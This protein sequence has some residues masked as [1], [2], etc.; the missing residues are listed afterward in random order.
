MPTHPALP[1]LPS[2]ASSPHSNSNP[3]QSHP[4]IVSDLISSLPDILVHLLPNFL[5]WLAESGIEYALF[6]CSAILVKFVL[7]GQPYHHCVEIESQGITDSRGD[8]I[9]LSLKRDAGSKIKMT[10]TLLSSVSFSPFS[11]PNVKSSRICSLSFVLMQAFGNDPSASLSAGIYAST[12]SLFISILLYIVA[13]WSYDTI[14]RN[15]KAGQWFYVRF[16]STFQ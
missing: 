11:L 14:L 13:F 9:L 15:G 8:E 10:G 2:P 7:L 1:G 6:V 3:P 16:R 5:R 12:T 4:S